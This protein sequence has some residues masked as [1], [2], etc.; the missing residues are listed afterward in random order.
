M[1]TREPHVTYRHSL[2]A[3][4]M[5]AMS[6]AL[7][8]LACSSSVPPKPPVAALVEG[9]PTWPEDVMRDAERADRVCTKRVT[10]LKFDQDQAKKKKEKFKTAMGSVTGAVGTAGGAIGAVGAFVIDSPD[11]MKQLTGVTG[12]VT[13]GLGAV[14]SV[15][16]LIVSPGETELKATT[17]ALEAIDKKRGEARDL[18]AKDPNKWSEDDKAAWAKAQQELMDLC[19]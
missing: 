16:T 9:E 10:A 6:L 13:A 15:V 11:T 18:L 5:L 4:I 17:A 7:T 3:P 12:I 8:S 14:G 1:T 19:K 2:G